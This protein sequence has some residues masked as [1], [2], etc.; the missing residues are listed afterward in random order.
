[1]PDLGRFIKAKREQAGLSQKELGEAAGLSDSSIQRI[2]VGSRKTPGW[3]T[4]CKIAKALDF[5]PFE[6]LAYAGYISDEDLKPYSQQIR[7][8]DE[9][10]Q[11]ELRCVQLF[12]DFVK[13]NRPIDEQ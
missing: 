13:A 7:G 6:I 9:L 2:E 8:L 4:L 1:M 12:T 11:E 10:T 5:H 3:D